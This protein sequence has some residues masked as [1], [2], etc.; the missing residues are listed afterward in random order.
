VYLGLNF[1]YG[2]IDGK[3]TYFAGGK[4]AYVANQQF[5]VG[6]SGVGFYSDQNHN[7]PLDN[8]DIF[9]GYGGLHIEPI[10]FGKSKF[11]MSI[12]VLVGGGAVAFSNTDF[13]D[14]F[15]HDHGHIE[16]WDPFFI[17]EPGLS[18]QYNI[19]RYLQFE[20]GAKYRITSNIDLFP[21]HINNLNGF[22]VGLGIKVGVFNMGRN[23]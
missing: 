6:F 10:F 16:D 13:D 21:S 12:P 20:L 5:E 18:V 23:N 19:S 17:V 15:E 1:G 11:S 14:F 22:S 3:S 7:G 2:E 8:N 4:I 9:G